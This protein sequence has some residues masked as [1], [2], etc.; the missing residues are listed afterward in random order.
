LV[1]HNGELDPDKYN[2]LEFEEQMHRTIGSGA[3]K[4]DLLFI[5]DFSGLFHCVDAKTGERYWTHDLFAATWGSPLIVEDL[6]DVGEEWLVDGAVQNGSVVFASL[7]RYGEPLLDY[8]AKA[9]VGVGRNVL[10]IFRVDGVTERETGERVRELTERSLAALGYTDGV[11][12]LELLRD[13]RSGE[14]LFGECAGRRGGAMVEEEVKVKRGFSL[15]GAAVDIALGRPVQPPPEVVEERYV[16]STYM[17]LPSGT[18]LRVAEPAELQRLGFVHDVHIS[19]LVGP[20]EPPS[21][22]STSY[23][24]GMCVVSG[25]TWDELESNMDEARRTFRERSVV[26]PTSRP[27]VE[28]REFMARQSKNSL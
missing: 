25:H 19:A 14:F 18:I 3:V 24:Q 13:R 22:M 21:V 11:F 6:V 8:T 26:A 10:R 2:E 12:H 16:G 4:N 27:R 5:A 9:Q 1:W 23:R 28:I 17:H 7:A 15:A 20:N